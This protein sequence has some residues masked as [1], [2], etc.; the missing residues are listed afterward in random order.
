VDE[1]PDGH[2]ELGVLAPDRLHFT[3]PGLGHVL[4]GAGLSQGTGLPGRLRRSYSV[5]KYPM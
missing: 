5:T 2:L 4:E 1:A 3:A